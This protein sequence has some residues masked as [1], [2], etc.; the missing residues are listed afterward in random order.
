MQNWSI[1]CRRRL[2]GP[3]NATTDLLSVFSSIIS[4]RI[5]RKILLL[6]L[7]AQVD[8]KPKKSTFLGLLLLPSSSGAVERLVVEKTKS[9]RYDF[10][11][12]IA[13]IL[14]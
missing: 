14:C 11:R 3:P 6:P 4:K 5:S 13:I 8:E 1:L 9:A 7:S 2:A 12:E 10:L